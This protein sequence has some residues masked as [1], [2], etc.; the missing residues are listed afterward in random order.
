M[1][2]PRGA[3]RKIMTAKRNLK[4][5]VR[6]RQAR[7]GES[8]VTARRQVLAARAPAPAAVSV[9]ELHDI[10]ADA[11][12][13][14]FR[15]RITAFSSLI[16]HAGPAGVAVA[17]RDAL[18]GARGPASARL[19]GTAFGVALPV[20]G[21]L[22]AELARDHRAIVSLNAMALDS[23]G[24]YLRELAVRARGWVAG[25]FEHGL[26]VVFHVA[27]PGG[28]VPALCIL[29]DHARALVLMP[30]S[31]LA[32]EVLGSAAPALF[33]IHDGRRYPVA[34]DEFLIGRR[35]TSDLVIRDG[36]ISRRHAA[37]VRRNGAY[38]LEDRGSAHGITYKGL[39]IGAKRIEDGDVFQLGAH[40]LSFSYR[41]EPDEP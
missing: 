26:A 22:P 27:G 41:A 28:S 31:G 35:P 21:P 24:L 8:Y 14:G 34:T 5:R 12:R 32:G 6:E 17:L 9:I 23:A 30:M 18:I 33:V 25:A 36:L 3:E 16:E 1:G 37:V 7:T 39:R 10:S 2:S 29:E 38:F 11:N 40:A 4:R 15:C 19:F 20:G 13:L